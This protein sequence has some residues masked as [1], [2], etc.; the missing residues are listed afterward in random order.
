MGEFKQM[1][2]ESQHQVISLVKKRKGK[3]PFSPTIPTVTIFVA[4]CLFEAKSHNVIA[5]K[6]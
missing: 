1:G 6:E 4:Y 3:Q 2:T 5:L